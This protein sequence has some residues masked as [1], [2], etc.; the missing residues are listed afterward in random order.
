M[1]TLKSKF[2]IYFINTFILAMTLN[3]SLIAKQI[4]ECKDSKGNILYTDHPKTNPNCFNPVPKNIEDP[5]TVNLKNSNIN[6]IKQADSTELVGAVAPSDDSESTINLDNN[7]DKNTG[8]YPSLRIT[9]PTN[10]EPVNSCGGQYTINYTSEPALRSGDTARL[11]VDDVVIGE[12]TTTS[13]D[14][15]NLERGPHRA[16]VQII[17]QG[18]VVQESA[19][20]HFNFMRNCAKH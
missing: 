4:Y 9:S 14:T 17:S 18:Q 6:S 13:F 3:S 15:K 5:R 12:A 8:S 10:N 19:T 7:Q 2:A 20:V 11:L 16:K 1:N